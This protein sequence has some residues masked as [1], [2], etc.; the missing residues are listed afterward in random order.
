MTATK[1]EIDFRCRVPPPE[2]SLLRF[3][4]DR[5]SGGQR[6]TNGQLK[7]PEEGS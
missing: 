1:P 4:V 6:L 3:T 5:D 7:L 2:S